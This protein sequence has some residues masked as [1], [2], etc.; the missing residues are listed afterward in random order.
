MR[1]CLFLPPRRFLQA[2]ETDQWRSQ[3]S[4]DKPLHQSKE[5]AEH[6]SRH[7]PQCCEFLRQLAF[8]SE[9]IADL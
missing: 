9:R 6:R 3:Q 4:R 8:F 1:L 2:G 5:E 7:G